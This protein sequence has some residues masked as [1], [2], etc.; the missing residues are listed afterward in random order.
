MNGPL[1]VRLHGDDPATAPQDVARLAMDGRRAV[2]EWTPAAIA[3][4]HGLDPL[5]YPLAP[6]LHRA[7]GDLFGGLHGFLA[8]ALPDAWGR[9]LIDRRLA[10]QGRRPETLT[11]L[12]RLALVGEGGRGA[13]SFHPA[14][15]APSEAGPLDLDALSAEALGLLLG[16]GEAGPALLRG[17]SASGGAR[18]KAHVWLAGDSAALAP[19]DGAAEWIVKFRAPGD[20]EDAGPLEAAYAAMAV[21]AGLEMAPVRL[22]PARTGAPYFATQRFDRTPPRPQGAQAR[23]GVAAHAAPP[24]SEGPQGRQR[25]RHQGSGREHQIT[26]AG[27]LEAPPGE[28]ALGYDQFFR[29]TRAITRNEADVAAAFARMVFNVLAHNRDDHARQHAF[30]MDE[31]GRWRL[32]PAYDLTWSAGPGGEHELDVAGEA[33]AISGAAVRRLGAAHGLKARTVE[34]VI[35]QVRAA[36]ADW[37][38]FAAAAGVSA[39]SRMGAAEAHAR[40]ARDFEAG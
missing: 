1:T 22:I 35:D 32:A 4:G 24:R 27:A 19:F 29:A 11:P 21:A 26:L 8:D 7:R 23:P 38:T 33:R 39:A 15:E 17:G 31:A 9:R 25:E 16:D 28:T 3:R 37:P 20:P 14:D 34:E 5:L 13:L 10:R 36:V 40:A 6:G 18:P 12:E 30:L 2:V